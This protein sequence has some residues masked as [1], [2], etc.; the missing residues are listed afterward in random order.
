[1][2]LVVVMILRVY[3]MYGQS[4]IALGILLATYIPLVIIG[5]VTP[6]VLYKPQFD[7]SGMQVDQSLK[8]NLLTFFSVLFGTKICMIS[9]EETPI[10]TTYFLIPMI[11]L[12]VLLC[13]LAVA[14]FARQ[15]LE[16]HRAIKKWRSNRYLELLVQES[17]IY[18]VVYATSRGLCCKRN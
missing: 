4:R 17:V 13:G 10:L 5:A 16:T 11:V 18:F 6:G 12:S 2:A 14:Q 3:A 1:M 9:F 7:V 15:S 8:C